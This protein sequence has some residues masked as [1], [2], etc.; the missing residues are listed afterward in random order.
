MSCE[1]NFTNSI[2]LTGANE[3]TRLLWRLGYHL[4]AYGCRR[5]FDAAITDM[6][7]KATRRMTDT[8]CETLRDIVWDSDKDIKPGEVYPRLQIITNLIHKINGIF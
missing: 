5:D 6:Y 3:D 1:I 4:N 2:A 8:D 7:L